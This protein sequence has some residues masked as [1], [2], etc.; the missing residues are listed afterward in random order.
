MILVIAIIASLIGGG[1]IGYAIT[2]LIDPASDGTLQNQ[3]SSL[4]QQVTGLQSLLNAAGSNISITYDSN[5]SLAQIYAQVKDSV[6]VVQGYTVQYDFFGRAFYSGVQGSGFVYNYNGKMIVI[7][8][9]HVI[10][11]TVNDTVTFANGDAYTATVLGADPYADLAALQTSA[12]ATE[13]KPLEIA[14][15]SSL[16]VGDPLIAVGGPY[17]LA[18]SMT[19]GIVSALGRT[20]SSDTST[21]YP[22][23]NVIQTSTPIN[24]GNS[25]GPLLNYEGQVVGITTAIVSNSQN[26]GFAIPSSTIL[27]EIG[28]LVTDGSYNQHPWIGASGID[29]TLDIAKA[30]NVNATYGWLVSGVTSNGPADKAGIEGG[31]KQ[32]NVAG[33]Q[34]T[35]GGDIIIA[36]DETRIR[37]TDDLSTYLE[38]NTLP[39]N[40]INV[41]VIRNGQTMTLALTLEPRPASA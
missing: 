27:R 39:G 2:T 24:P 6:V 29:M 40:T 36:F 38:E 7:T 21:S 18:G 22:I 41:T 34:V 1:I 28:S 4:Q 33:S 20:I 14:S 8:N 5:S 10:E 26:L 3:I 12:P 17:G 11:G 13:Y 15:S 25:G 32:I 30:L 9:N 37:N 31:T 35:V 23:A 19:T 16:N